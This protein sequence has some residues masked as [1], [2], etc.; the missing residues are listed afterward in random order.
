MKNIG[1]FTKQF[2]EKE[3]KRF[4]S[5]LLVRGINSLPNSSFV[6]TKLRLA[7]VSFFCRFVTYSC[8]F[9]A[10]NLKST[11]CTVHD[12]RKWVKIADKIG[13]SVNCCLSMHVK[14]IIKVLKNYY[15]YFALHICR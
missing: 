15:D 13:S 6:I 10:S 11:E 1:I 12:F 5:I 7:A 3:Y 14:D 8:V 4:V 2:Y 9:Y